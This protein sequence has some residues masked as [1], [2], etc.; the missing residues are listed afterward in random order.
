ML[1]I[2]P[3]AMPT[4]ADLVPGPAPWRPDPRRA[5]L[6]I[7]DMQ[8]YFVGFLP[9]GASPTTELLANIAALRAAGLPVIYSAQPGRMSRADRGLL[10]DVWGP[11]MTDDPAN[12]DVVAA[13]APGPDDLVLT[14]WRYSAFHRT[15]L[16][17]H[18]AATGRD[19]LIVCGVFA[20]L[21]CLLTACDAYAHDVEA[22]LV[23]DA[24]A[25]FSAADHRLA[26]DYAA[27]ACAVTLTTAQVLV[28]LGR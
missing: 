16:A 7:H 27:R 13:L 11:G 17:E 15:G 1:T 19:Q 12:R 8:G 18:L 9:S 2:Q 10:H 21:G 4:A 3:Y 22:F 5:A 6:L 24:V 28:Q 14:K 25:A 20:H 23:A 26:L